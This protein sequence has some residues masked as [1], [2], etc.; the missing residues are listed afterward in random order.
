LSVPIEHVQVLEKGGG[1][2]LT[3]HLFATL[4]SEDLDFYRGL[5]VL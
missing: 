3:S 1:G 4:R 5:V 2:S